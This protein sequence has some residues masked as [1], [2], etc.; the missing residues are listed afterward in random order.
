MADAVFE[1][2]SLQIR[3]QWR[4]RIDRLLE[5]LQKGPATLRLSYIGD[6]EDAD[7]VEERLAAVQQQIR[8]AWKALDGD[9]ELTIEPEIFWRR[10]A[11]LNE[12]SAR[13]RDGG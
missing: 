9:Y 4:P 3:P 11:P 2:G 1:R 8:D 5:E 13:M 12:T 10:G 6:V 7:L